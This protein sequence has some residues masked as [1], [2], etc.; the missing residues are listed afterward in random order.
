MLNYQRVY[1]AIWWNKSNLGVIEGYELLGS[2][3]TCSPRIATFTYGEIVDWQD[4]GI[5]VSRQTW[6]MFNRIHEES[7]QATFVYS[8][9]ISTFLRW[10]EGIFDWRGIYIYIY[11]LSSWAYQLFC[12]VFVQKCTC[13]GIREWSYPQRR[14]VEV[15]STQCNESPTPM[16]SRLFRE[17]GYGEANHRPSH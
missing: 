2:I 15:Q 10:N 13:I 3:W 9:D 5:P 8:A 6:C 7:L 17:M 12:R 14:N 16:K 4:F 1:N 11:I